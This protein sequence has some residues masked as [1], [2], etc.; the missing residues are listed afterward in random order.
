MTK[1]VTIK[2]FAENSSLPAQLIRATIRQFGDW[3][4]FKQSAPDISSHGATGGFSGFTYYDDTVPFAKRNKK[5]ILESLTEMDQQIENVGLLAFIASFNCFKGMDIT[6]DS[7]ARAI[8][9]GK[10]DDVITVF[11]ALAW[12]ALEEVARSYNDFIEMDR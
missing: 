10:G 1:N 12:Y 3:D 4:Y 8:Y 9:T 7:I 5:L 2:Q 11:N 6:Q